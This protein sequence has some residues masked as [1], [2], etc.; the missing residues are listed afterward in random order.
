MSKLLSV[1]M[2]AISLEGSL[3]SRKGP[4]GLFYFPVQF[5]AAPDKVGVMRWEIVTSFNGASGFEDGEMLARAKA[6]ELG[7]PYIRDLQ[8]GIRVE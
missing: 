6:A 7:I 1:Y 5:R 2:D 4:T 3:A 8:A